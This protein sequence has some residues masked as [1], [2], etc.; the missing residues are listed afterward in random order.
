MKIQLKLDNFSISIF[1]LKHL[2]SYI[3]PS[4]LMWERNY[5]WES[6]QC[7]ASFWRC[8]LGC[9]SCALHYPRTWRRGS[10][11][12][13]YTVSYVFPPYEYFFMS[14]ELYIQN[15]SPIIFDVNSLIFLYQKYEFQTA[16][17]GY[18]YQVHLCQI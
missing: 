6:W 8:P 16:Q 1:I 17:I 12:Q 13:Y 2:T 18:C 5:W 15:V 3:L 4:P 9:Y 14:S 11:H 7:H 10:K